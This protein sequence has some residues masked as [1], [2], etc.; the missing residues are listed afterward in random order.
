MRSNPSA[1]VFVCIK[2]RR[3]AE[4]PLGV[5]GMQSLENCHPV[6]RQN[7]GVL[8]SHQSSRL[9]LLKQLRV[10]RLTTDGR[11]TFQQVRQED[12]GAHLD[13]RYRAPQN[14]L[15]HSERSVAGL[16]RSRLCPQC[17]VRFV[18][19]CWKELSVLLSCLTRTTY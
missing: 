14:L 4:A 2:S 10:R 9:T 3:G 5:G 15:F 16:P 19:N 7:N 6:T 11:V 13:T 1:A 18:K 17:L 8:G 12:L